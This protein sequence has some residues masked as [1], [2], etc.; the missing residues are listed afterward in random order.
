MRKLITLTTAALFA[1]TIAMP[2]HAA[3][4]RPDSPTAASS[5]AAD[6]KADAKRYCVESEATGS[7]LVK[8]ICKTRA[9]W[10]ADDNFDPLAPQR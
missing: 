5:P 10:I 1:A 8:K 4:K 9:D 2:A 3:P 7:R 6:P